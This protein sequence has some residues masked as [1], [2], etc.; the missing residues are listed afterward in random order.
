MMEKKNLYKFIHMPLLKMKPEFFLRRKNDA[1][2]NKKVT[3]KKEKSCLLKPKRRR[4][5]RGGGGGGGG[6]KQKKASTSPQRTVYCITPPYI[7]MM[8]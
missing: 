1:N 7:N 6:E 5:R 3:K 8:M 4:R 2:L